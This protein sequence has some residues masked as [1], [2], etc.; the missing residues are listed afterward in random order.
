MIILVSTTT[1]SDSDRPAPAATVPSGAA[2]PSVA[3]PAT[4]DAVPTAHGHLCA[5][6]HLN[7]PRSHFCVVC[8]IRMTERTGTLVEGL[9][10]PLG[11]LVFDDGATYTV[12][13]DYLVG[14]DPES[15]RRVG[16]GELRPLVVTDQAVS[17][18]RAHL[19]IRLC[20]WDVVCMDT[21]SRNGTFVALPGQPQWWL[22]P[23]QQTFRLV[24][25]T[26]VRIGTR[27]FVFHSP[28]GVR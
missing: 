6:G 26:R 25:G 19:E 20:G 2:S 11:L 15:D 3:R 5:H 7:D 24:P 17:V 8:G 12:D 13:G 22:P 23:A 14:R 10:P 21:G 28:S 16:S 18:S 1:L 9:R 4:D 27:G